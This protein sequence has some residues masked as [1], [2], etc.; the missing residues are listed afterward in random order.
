MTA[1]PPPAPHWASWGWW[2]GG[3]QIPQDAVVCN[4]LAELIKLNVFVTED[5]RHF[6]EAD[7]FLRASTGR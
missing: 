5:H 6:W 4:K 1:A 7:E 3:K 2:R